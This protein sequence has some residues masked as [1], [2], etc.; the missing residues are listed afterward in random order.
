[1]DMAY[2]ELEFVLV[3]AGGQVRTH[4]QFVALYYFNNVH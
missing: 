2:A 4:V 1:M 3:I